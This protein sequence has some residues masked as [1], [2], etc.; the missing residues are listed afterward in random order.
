MHARISED[1]ADVANQKR[2]E[3]EKEETIN[4]LSKRTWALSYRVLRPRQGRR[5]TI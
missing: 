1:P 2:F 5:R 3:I 4:A